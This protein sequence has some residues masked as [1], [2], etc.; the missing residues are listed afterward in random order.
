MSW[1]HAVF[2]PLCK[3]TDPL[4]LETSE[5]EAIHSL[6]LRVSRLESLSPG[7]REGLSCFSSSAQLTLA[8]TAAYIVS[9]GSPSLTPPITPPQVAP[10]RTIQSQ[11]SPYQPKMSHGRIFEIAGNLARIGFGGQCGLDD[12]RSSWNISRP[13]E[14]NRSKIVDQNLQSFWSSTSENQ[15]DSVISRGAFRRNSEGISIDF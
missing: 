3:G 7:H 12:L 2:C 1:K 8:A 9:P 11:V 5:H 4:R 6:A 14:A 15:N 10:R 13:V